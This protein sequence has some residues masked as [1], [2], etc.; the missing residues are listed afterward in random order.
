MDTLRGVGEI[1][2][3][4]SVPTSG[5]RIQV[6]SPEGE[7]QD[8]LLKVDL[9]TLQRRVPGTDPCPKPDRHSSQRL[10]DHLASQLGGEELVVQELEG[11]VRHLRVPP[12]GGP[13]SAGSS[14]G[15]G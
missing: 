12:R 13:L 9:P 7:V 4:D 3:E 8:V 1:A 11:T 15:M 6:G 10:V 2:V 14:G 5:G